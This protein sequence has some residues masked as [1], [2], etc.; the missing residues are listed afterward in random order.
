M[1]YF[2]ILLVFIIT[3]CGT[4][5]EAG[6]ILRNEKKATNDEFLIQKKDPLVLPPN[7]EIVPSPDS[8]NKKKTSNDEKIKE[9]LKAPRSENIKTK[10][11]TS[12]EE[13]ILNKIRK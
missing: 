1:K 9:I 13:S 5:T 2:L 3:S 11:S 4:V 10:K 6:K 12:T 7:Y 8:I